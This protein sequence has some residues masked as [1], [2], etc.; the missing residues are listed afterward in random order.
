MK[1]IAM[2][3]ETFKKKNETTD[4]LSGDF[5]ELNVR[6]MNIERNMGELLKYKRDL[7]NLFTAVKVLAGPKWS[8]ISKSIADDDIKFGG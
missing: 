3:L 2:G 1:I 6:L 5:R 4:K 7:R 8:G